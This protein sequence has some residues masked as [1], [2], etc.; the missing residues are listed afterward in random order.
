MG[1]CVITADHTSVDEVRYLG[2]ISIDW[3][4]F[5]SVRISVVTLDRSPVHGYADAGLF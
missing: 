3:A 1:G 4:G 5:R 2:V